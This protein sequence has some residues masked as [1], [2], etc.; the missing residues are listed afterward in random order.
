VRVLLDVSAVPARPVGAGVYTVALASGLARRA[1]DVE[2]HLLAR[3]GDGDRWARWAP[4]ASVHAVAPRSRP[5]RLAWEQLRGPS[6]AA[7]VAPDV[8]HGPHYTMPARSRVPTVVTIHD[9]T[10]FDHPEWHERSK[11]VFFRRMIRTS[12]AHADVLVCVSEFTARRLRRLVAPSG[13]VLVIEHGVDHGRF[14]VAGDRDVDLVLLAEHGVVPPYVAFVGTIEPRK[15]VP[16]LVRAFAR[17]AATRRDLRLVV[18]GADGWDAARVRE[19]IASSGVATRVVRPGYLPDATLTA[20]YRQAAVMAYPSIEEGF[21]L[22]ALE[23]LACGT[24]LVT[25]DGSALAEIV[26]DAA[27]LVPPGDADALAGALT[28]VLDDDD[29]ATRLRMA[30]PERASEY[31]WDRTVDLHLEAYA[32]AANTQMVDQ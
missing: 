14:G 10:F 27:L 29:L 28:T 3:A 17:I 24:P 16:T 13:S 20:L 32:R 9:M 31:T 8:W 1:G 12:A 11:V 25:T 18:A 30:G 4:G 21:G 26:A 23:A 15:D 7:R 19:A 5:A 22:P 2:L 6:F